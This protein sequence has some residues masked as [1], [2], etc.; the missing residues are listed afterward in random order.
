MEAMPVL[1]HPNDVEYTLRRCSAMRCCA[2]YLVMYVEHLRSWIDLRAD[3]K[4]VVGFM[5]L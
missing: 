1:I 4:H 5:R 3:L 2:L